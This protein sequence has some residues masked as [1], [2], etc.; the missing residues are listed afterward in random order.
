MQFEFPIC[1]LTSGRAGGEHFGLQHGPVAA[2]QRD[3]LRRASPPWM[4]GEGSP[5]AVIC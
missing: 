4:S 2:A 3:A 5:A 1:R